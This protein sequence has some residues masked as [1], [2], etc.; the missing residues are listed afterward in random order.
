MEYQGISKKGHQYIA[1]SHVQTAA[2]NWSTTIIQYRDYIQLLPTVLMH[3]HMPLY[4]CS[5][6]PKPRQQH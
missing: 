2:M 6:L 3:M 5:K 4:V 1:V